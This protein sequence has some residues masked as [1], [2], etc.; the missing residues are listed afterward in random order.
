MLR[1]TRY[2]AVGVV[3]LLTALGA[4][5]AVARVDRGLPY[6]PQVPRLVL[7]DVIPSRLPFQPT[8]AAMPITRYLAAEQGHGPRTGDLAEM[9]RRK[10]LRVLM[11]REQAGELGRRDIAMERELVTGFALQHGMVAEFVWVDT[12]GELPQA[13]TDGRGDVVIG[14]SPLDAGEAH[15]ID[16]TVA[17]K[18]VR[19]L[20]VARRGE[21]KLARKSDLYGLRAGL[22][23]GS[24]AWPVLDQMSAGHPA[25]VRVPTEGLRQEEVLAQLAAG[26]FDFTVIESDGS[27]PAL[28]AHP[29]LR[30]AM[31]L[32]EGQPVSWL[33]RAAN[34]ELRAALDHHL[35]KNRLA[36][37]PQATA[38]EDLDVIRKRGVLRVITRPD[39]D[40][41]FI[42]KG[43]PAGFEYDLIR[44]F[45]LREGL[46]L[47]VT[48]ADS[49][50]QMLA[51][52]RDGL[53]DVVTARVDARLAEADASLASTRIYH[54]VAPVIVGRAD[55][56]TVLK[57]GGRVLVAR[58]G[59]FARMLGRDGARDLGL[60][61]DI[62]ETEPSRTIP[63]LVDAVAAGEADYTV[64]E[65][66]RLKELGRYRDDVRPLRSIRDTRP[67][68]YT[69][70]SSNP[71]LRAA[72]DDFLKTEY[73][74]DLYR[75]AQR[76][77]FDNDDLFAIRG[78]GFDRLSPYD[79]LV[80]RY[81]DRY[82]F[83]WRLIVAQIY[84]ESRFKPG[85]VS[86][87]GARGLMQVLPKTARAMGFRRLDHPEHGIHAGVKY[88]DRQRDRFEDTLAI[89]DRTWFALA[90]YHAGYERVQSA[91]RRAARM[92]LDPNRWFGNVEKAM[93]EMSRKRSGRSA[94]RGGAVTASYV[95]EVRARYES[96]LLMRPGAVLAAL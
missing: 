38:R 39:A 88:L 11:L 72:L 26:R 94:Y 9:Q 10:R 74:S 67:Y 52:L 41:F 80:K 22:A 8:P 59:L 1:R 33:V 49:D 61:L 45:C 91:R 81:A 85:A 47:E 36:L 4:G 14:D 82:G 29:T 16:R 32:T 25:I 46:R 60:E 18:Q 44:E 31:E 20:V 95:R 57:A 17:L 83:D 51:W 30:V 64:V 37:R 90:A 76:R 89:A 24:P 55:S 86:A 93:V 27:E 87:A 65:A 96:Y 63:E 77:Y 21:R 35:N 3:S 19:Y 50:E 66:S 79:E 34:E 75:A 6:E 73:G 70:R 23:A 48:V 2:G 62:V 56:G 5:Q 53:G 15:G 7:R 84:E 78:A 42:S 71:A 43:E 13:L 54:Y 68:R 12:P 40:D 28:D 58:D 92:G 69:V